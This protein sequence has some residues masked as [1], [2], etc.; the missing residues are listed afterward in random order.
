MTCMIHD[1]IHNEYWLLI[2]DPHSGTTTGQCCRTRCITSTTNRRTV[3]KETG[4]ETNV[5][6]VSSQDK[7]FQGFQC[8]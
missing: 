5:A 2:I 6:I 4:V 7:T 8:T 1:N 3:T